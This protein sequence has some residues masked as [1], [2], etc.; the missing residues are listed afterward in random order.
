MAE[1]VLRVQDLD[2][3]GKDYS[4]SVTRDWLA[5]VLADTDVAAA[6]EA[7]DGS[8]EFH[9]QKQGEDVVVHGRLKAHLVAECAR[10]LSDAAIDV[11]MDFG[12]L[13][14]ARGANLRPEPDEVDLTPEDLEREFYSGDEIVLDDVVRENLLLEVPIKPL[15]DEACEGIEVPADVAGPDDLRASAEGGVDPRFAPLLKLVGQMKPTEE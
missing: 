5:R 1:F 9:A 4:F 12:G 6:E 3:A 11:D 7:D 2:E 14:T 13:F 8:L 10:C 15:C